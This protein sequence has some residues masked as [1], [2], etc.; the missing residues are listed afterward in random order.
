MQR[1]VTCMPPDGAA[2]FLSA[3][4]GSIFSNE[5]EG[6]DATGDCLAP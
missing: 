2:F 5:A 1:V 6:R 4:T 3:P